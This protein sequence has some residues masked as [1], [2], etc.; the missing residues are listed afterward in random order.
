MKSLINEGLCNVDS[1]N[2]IEGHR[3]R[4]TENALVFTELVHR[5]FVM[6]LEF[7][8]DIVG[9]KDG[10]F[11]DP[12]EPFF[13][14]HQDIDIRPQHDAEVAVERR[15]VSDGIGTVV[16]EHIRAVVPFHHHRNR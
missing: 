2:S 10:V 4:D 5:H 9:V 6:A 15:D 11:R 14:E 7:L 16:F 1:V 8:F 13:A 12:A 3:L